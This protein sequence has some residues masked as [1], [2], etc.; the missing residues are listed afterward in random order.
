MGKRPWSKQIEFVQSVIENRNTAVRSGHSVGKTEGAALLCEWWFSCRGLCFYTTA[1]GLDAVKD[2]LWKALKANRESALRP[3]LLPG[4]ITDK[5]QLKVDGQA[6]WWGKGFATNKAERG[7][8]RHEVGLLVVADEAAGVEPF[9]WDALNSSMASDDVR[10]LIIG[11]PNNKRE[12][13]WRAFH[14]ES[15]RWNCIHISSY[16]SPN[17]T[18]KEPPVPGLA[19]EV[20]IADMLIE[21]KDEPNKFRNRVLGE[22]TD[23]DHNEKIIPVRWIVEAQKLYEELLEEEPY[24]DEPVRY[25]R[26]FVDVA[27]WGK[28][29]STLATWKGQRLQIEFESEDKSDEGLMKL[30]EDVND[31][32]MGLPLNDKPATIGVD[33]DAVG[34]GVFSRL[35]QLYKNNRE[36]WGRCKPIKFHWGWKSTRPKDFVALID[37][38]HWLLRESLDPSKP[39][40]ERLAIQPGEEILNHLNMRKYSTDGRERTK[41]EN[42]DQLKSRNQK[43]P[44]Y[45]DPIVGC[46]HTPNVVKAAML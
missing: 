40:S 28:D 34:A 19:T 44:D 2:G 16:D 9:V 38:L 32:V 39:R 26:A 7:Q 5:P 29:K 43:S 8:G 22:F 31:W 14:T 30:A 23:L 4:N 46:M 20:W 42:K 36:R 33:C 6:D 27:G 25:H 13:F 24:Y 35:T 21:H 41:V 3:D 11:N 10:M 45:A 12:K 37:E 15:A 18:K 1:P 17:I